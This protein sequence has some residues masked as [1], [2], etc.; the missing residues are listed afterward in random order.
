MRPGRAVAVAI[1]AAAMRA[2][3]AVAV[4]ILAGATRA[5]CARRRRSTR[6]AVPRHAISAAGDRPALARH[7]PRGISEA[8]DVEAEAGEAEGVDEV[9]HCRYAERATRLQ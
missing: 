2:G 3:R 7:V 6:D 8:A 4:A 1:S 5:A 9:S